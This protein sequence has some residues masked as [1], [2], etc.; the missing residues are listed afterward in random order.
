MLQKIGIHARRVVEWAD[1]SHFQSTENKEPFLSDEQKEALR[2]REI[3][4][5]RELDDV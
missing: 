2:K 1:R 3:A 4:R 5:Q